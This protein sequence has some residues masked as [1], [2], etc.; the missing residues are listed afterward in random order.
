LHGVKV[1]LPL[2]EV[3]RVLVRFHHVARFIVNADHSIMWVAPFD[4]PE[5]TEW[6]RIGN[7]SVSTFLYKSAKMLRQTRSPSWVVT[8]KRNPRPS[9]E[10]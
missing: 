4:V 6:Q 3:A 7:Q 10:K 9:A 1:T 5:P 8:V 2:F